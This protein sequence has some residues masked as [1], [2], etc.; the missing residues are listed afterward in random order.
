MISVLV[1]SNQA[2]NAFWHWGI[3]EFCCILILNATTR[4][5]IKYYCLCVLFK[6]YLGFVCETINNYNILADKILLC[7]EKSMNKVWNEFLIKSTKK[8]QIKVESLKMYSLQE[9]FNGSNYSSAKDIVDVFSGS[10]EVLS[11]SMYVQCKHLYRYE[12]EKLRGIV[13]PSSVQFDYCVSII[14]SYTWWFLTLYYSE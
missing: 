5:Y 4:K 9:Y 1:Y 6:C 10:R 12:Q 13:L 7:I 14:I 3:F 8:V 2:Y 11:A